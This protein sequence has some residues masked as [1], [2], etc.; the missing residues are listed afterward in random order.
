MTWRNM[1][2]EII[3]ESVVELRVQLGKTE[4][5]GER[6]LYLQK[7]DVI[8]LDQDAK[9]MLTG[10]IDGLPKVRGYAGIQRGLQAFKI[11]DRLI[12]R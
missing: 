4:I 9:E 12:I 5:S 7:G 11:M 3:L 10:Y 6:L 2:E 1:L 8:Q